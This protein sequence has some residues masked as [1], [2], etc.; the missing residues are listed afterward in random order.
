MSTLEREVQTFQLLDF[1]WTECP[2][3]PILRSLLI[4][5]TLPT[6]KCGTLWSTLGFWGEH[7][8]MNPS[9]VLLCQPEKSEPKF[10]GILLQWRDPAGKHMGPECK[11]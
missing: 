4:T 9:A 10:S 3:L 5:S 6:K 7:P 1:C 11:G 2:M 8:I